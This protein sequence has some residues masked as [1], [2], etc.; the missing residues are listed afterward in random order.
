MNLTLHS[1]IFSYTHKYNTRMNMF[2]MRAKKKTHTLCDAELYKINKCALYEYLS[3]NT[4]VYYYNIEICH[5][6][7]EYI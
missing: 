5:Y 2:I 4:Y 6:F 1:Y 3:V 7:L